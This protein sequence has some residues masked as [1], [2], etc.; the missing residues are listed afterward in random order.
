V[1]TLKVTVTE[2]S[3]LLYR[4]KRRLLT[5]GKRARGTGQGSMML[6]KPPRIILC[7][8]A[9]LPLLSLLAMQVLSLPPIMLSG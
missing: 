2:S 8:R 5:E 3:L 1:A 4:P 7:N 9:N 6:K